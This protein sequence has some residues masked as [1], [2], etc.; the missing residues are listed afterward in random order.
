MKKF[1]IVLP[2]YHPPEG[3]E[4]PILNAIRNIR[5]HLGNSNCE[6]HLY[7]TN[8]GYPV[9][10]YSKDALDRINQAL[11]QILDM[12]KQ[13]SRLQETLSE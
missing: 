3:W 2:L 12:K 4:I 10:Y 7:L 1:D 5:Q 6:L 8:D 11:D 13:V 9:E